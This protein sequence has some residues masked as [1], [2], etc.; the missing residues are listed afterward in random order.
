MKETRFIAQNKEKWLESEMLLKE[1]NKD[2]EKLSNLFTQVMDDLSYSRTHYPNRS[3][4]VYLNKI[5]REYFSLIYGHKK[6]RKNRF[7]SFW[8][9]EIPQIIL[10]GKKELMI[11]LVIFLFSAAIGIFSSIHD[12]GFTSTILGEDYVAMTKENISTGDPMAVYKKSHQADMVFRI[13]YNNLKVAFTTYVFGIFLS[14]GTI[15]IMIYNGIMVGCFQFFFIER[16]L[17]L[18]SALTI[19]LHG[20]LEISSII[21]AGG[22]GLML[23]SGLVFP[24]SYSRIQAFQISGIRSLK[25]MLGISPVIILAAIIE[26]FLTR[27]SDMPDVIKALLIILSAVFIIGYFVVYPWLKSRTGFE[28]PLEKVRLAPSIPEVTAF[29]KIKNNAEILKDTFQFYKKFIGKLLPAISII[30]VLMAIAHM[31]WTPE[32]TEFSM[33]SSFFDFFFSSL[34]FALSVPSPEFIL[35]NAVGT[36]L[37]LYRVYLLVDRQSR[38][39]T[40]GGF[41][42]LSLGQIVFFCGLIYFGLHSLGG[43]GALL[44]VLIFLIFLLANFIQ[45]NERINL[46]QGIVN[47]VTLYRVNFGQ[48]LGLQAILLLMT[49]SFLM[50]MSAPLLYFNLEILQWNFARNDEWAKTVVRFVEILVKVFAFNL[51]LPIIGAGAS[52]L[53]FSLSEIHTAESLKRAIA[54][55]GTK[56]TR[57]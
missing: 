32:R 2:P 12:P 47:S 51:V 13:T 10:Y 43:W 33:L 56:Q 24:G 23:G 55:V 16:G 38:H 48:T 21:L 57:R 25:L 37:I 8:L 45:H 14:I 46:L 15:A 11:S 1:S 17:L 34:S 49:V 52:Y 44:L 20:T 22:A 41:S 3:V 36:G 27:Y 54:R 9:D 31:V 50:I 35:V 7:A 26:S 28:H 30:S 19:W 53:Y 6:E 42:F 39:E 18:E 40:T 4:R 5:G 29:D